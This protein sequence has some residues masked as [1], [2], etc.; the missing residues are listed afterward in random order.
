LNAQKI[1]IVEDSLL[2]VA[3]LKLALEA[4]GFATLQ[5]G[6]GVEAL[7]QARRERPDAILS[8]VLMPKMDGFQL[9]RA[10][11]CDPS[12]RQIPVILHS[13]VYKLDEDRNL[14]MVAGADAYI[15][16]GAAPE[17]LSGLIQQVIAA[18][19]D[20]E[21]TAEAKP[22]IGQAQ[23]DE[24]HSQRTLFHLLEKTASLEQANEAL[25]QFRDP[26]ENSAD[27]DAIIEGWV[28]ALDVRAK[29]ADGHTRRVTEMTVNLARR[30]GIAEHE[31]IHIRRGALLHDI[32]KMGIPDRILLKTGPLNDEEW[33]I[34]RQHPHLAY[35][36]LSPIVHLQP[37]L[38]IPYCHHEKWDGTGYP[39][40]L[41]GAQIPLAAR[42]FAVVDVWDSL[43]SD[44]LYRDSYPEEKVRKQIRA[45]SGT[46][47]DPKIV[48]VFEPLLRTGSLD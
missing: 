36:L 4:Q 42:I 15:P 47:F 17:E 34:M 46:H 5:A 43:R 39:R 26:G 8:D 37:A 33:A 1:L 7:E 16:K 22:E 30:V 23:F 9:C 44:H 6:N 45:L 21:K 28:E 11:R 25:A 24:L 12:L 35:E 40:G 2:Q 10:I 31:L 19:Q 32:G 38:D 14:G 27:Y 20:P 48:K 29:E 3:R 13:A 41:K 18:K